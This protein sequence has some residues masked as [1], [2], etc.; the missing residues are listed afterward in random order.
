M[1]VAVHGVR[2]DAGNQDDEHGKPS[3][4]GP[5]VIDLEDEPSNKHQDTFRSSLQKTTDRPGALHVRRNQS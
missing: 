1:H 2:N 5:T 4:N 3:L